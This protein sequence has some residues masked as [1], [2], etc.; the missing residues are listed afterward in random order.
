MTK[1]EEKKQMRRMIRALER[2]LPAAYKAQSSAGIAR[3]LLAMP[4]YQLR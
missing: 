1:S 3:H 4:E 2:E